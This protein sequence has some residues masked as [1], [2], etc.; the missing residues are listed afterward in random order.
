MIS[1][2]YCS[3]LVQITCIFKE[4]NGTEAIFSWIFH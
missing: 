4:K 3:A 2:V 1:S